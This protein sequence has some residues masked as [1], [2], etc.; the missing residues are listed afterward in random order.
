MDLKKK[1]K[2]LAINELVKPWILPF[3]SIGI[4]FLLGSIGYRITEGWDFGDCLWMV[5]ITITTIGFGEVETLSAAGRIVTFLIIGGGL[6][7]VQL[8]LQHLLNLS[9]NG[10]FS[11]VRELRF[12]RRL[13]RMQNHI[14]I[15]GYGR[16]GSEIAKQL[17]SKKIPLLI[18]ESNNDT[19]M[20]AEKDGFDVLEADATLD[21]TLI[22][23]GINNCRTLIVT[24]DTD[25][26]NLYVILSSKGLSSKCKLIARAETEESQNKLKL[27]G[28][29]LV[30]S[31][32][33]EAAKM[34][35]K[36]SI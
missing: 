6:V 32:Y 1:L 30:V 34:I 9:A 20:V 29:S 21:Q 18:I 35:V 19:K 22:S 14:I 12:R 28:A 24:L 4:I 10:Y 26:A 25:A 16:V 13:I 7:V 15:C 33:V 36:E 23:A 31:P 27:A 8:S 11:R 3:F 2:I 5:L 17:K